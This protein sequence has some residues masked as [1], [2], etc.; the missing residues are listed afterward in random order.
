M[1]RYYYYLLVR[2]G[3]GR[4]FGRFAPSLTPSTSRKVPQRPFH[5]TAVTNTTL[6]VQGSRTV[7]PSDQAL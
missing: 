4:A 2:I 6:T 1:P 3:F 7:K 5:G